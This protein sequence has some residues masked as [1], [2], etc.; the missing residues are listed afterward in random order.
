[1]AEEARI[2]V[3]VRLFATFREGR[4]IAQ[5]RKYPAGTAVDYII[6]ELNIPVPDIGIIML[7]SR[8]AEGA[9]ILKDG[10]RLAIFPKIGGG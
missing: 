7:N 2:C 6:E 1:M 8:H 3:D 10:D 4:F 9:T 5:P